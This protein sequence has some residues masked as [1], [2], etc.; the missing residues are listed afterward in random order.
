[1]P[2]LAMLDPAGPYADL[3]VAHTLTDGESCLSGLF[4]SSNENVYADPLLI[5]PSPTDT[6][7]VPLS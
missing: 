7:S 5:P 2:L 6:T 3:I 4:L 1:M